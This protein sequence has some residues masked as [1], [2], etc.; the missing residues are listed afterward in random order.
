MKPALRVQVVAMAKV[1]DKVKVTIRNTILGGST[2]IG[3]DA[4]MSVN[5][6]IVED[7]GDSWLIELAISVNG[8]NRILVSKAAQA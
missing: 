4:P 1:G 2:A 3:P 7:Y 5:G 6:T 8:K